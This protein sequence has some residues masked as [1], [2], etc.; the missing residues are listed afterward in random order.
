M[1]VAAN[2]RK[3]KSGKREPDYLPR[4]VVCDGRRLEPT[5]SNLSADLPQSKSSQ[6]KNN[7]RVNL[8]FT[9][10]VKQLLMHRQAEHLPTIGN[11][12]SIV[13]IIML[14]IARDWLGTP[15]SDAKSNVTPF[16]RRANSERNNLKY[17][18]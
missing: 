12:F 7:R 10:H 18:S 6:N 17:L 11:P 2:V 15:S 4:I 1:A 13:T 16:V 9:H 5:I 14:A 8:L 3:E